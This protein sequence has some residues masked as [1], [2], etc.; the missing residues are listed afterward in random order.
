MNNVYL[1]SHCDSCLSYNSILPVHLQS[2]FIHLI[3]NPLIYDFTI[4]IG[5]KSFIVVLAL[6]VGVI[7]F[8]NLFIDTDY[9]SN[10]LYNVILFKKKKG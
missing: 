9:L 3:I 2:V 4:I 1:Y 5:R 6:H 10:H 8:G 7:R